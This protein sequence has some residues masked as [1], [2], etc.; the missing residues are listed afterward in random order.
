MSPLQKLLPTPDLGGA[1]S[2]TDAT[3]PTEVYQRD[4]PAF[5]ICVKNTVGSTN[6][7]FTDSVAKVFEWL[8]FS[9]P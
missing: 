7:D 1:A 2:Q 8:F 4:T 3:V 6:R 5:G 9:W